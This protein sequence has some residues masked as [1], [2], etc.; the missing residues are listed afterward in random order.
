MND[1]DKKSCIDLSTIF[2]SNERLKKYVT[3]D[4]I[5]KDSYLRYQEK[6]S[7]ERAKKKK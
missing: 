3:F 6:Q 4:G 2:E 7:S 1:G 5:K